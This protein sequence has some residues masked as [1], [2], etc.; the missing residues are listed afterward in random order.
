VGGCTLEAAE[1]V[2]GDCGFAI[3]DFGLDVK[4]EAI[5]KPILQIQNGPLL[6]GIAALMNQSLLRREEELAGQPRFGML[7]TIHEF[8]AECLAASGEEA[9][10]RRRHARFFLALAERMECERSGPSRGVWVRRLQADYDNLRAVLDWGEAHGEAQV[11]LRLAHMRGALWAAG[12]RRSEG[13]QCLARLLAGEDTQEPTA[14]RAR[15]LYLASE[16][17]AVLGDPGRAEQLQQECQAIWRELG[18]KIGIARSLLHLAGYAR[19]RCDHARARS[20]WD[21]SLGV[22]QEVADKETIAYVL[23]YGTSIVMAL[24]DPALAR[25][26]FEQGLALAQELGHKVMTAAAHEDLARVD[27]SQGEWAAAEARLRKSLTLLRD[28]AFLSHIPDM[29]VSLAGLAAVQGHAERAARL[30]GAAEALGEAMEIQRSLSVQSAFEGDI[31]CAR[32]A[33]SEE[34]FAAAWA[35]GRALSLDQSIDYA[36]EA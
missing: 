15:A 6:E 13:W 3:S 33:L 24:G 22:A 4:L 8:A 35:E 9:A 25:V 30:F 7:E 16:L 10:I 26:Y 28:A 12:V 32:T 21:E 2:C 29:L 20:L 19:F 34:T 27:R 14:E 18:D 17:V 5:Q 11:A 23:V 36:L 1:A 31:T